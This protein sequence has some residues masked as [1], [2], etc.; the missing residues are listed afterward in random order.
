[1]ESRFLKC[2]N[3]KVNMFCTLAVYAGKN[4][5]DTDFNSSFSVD[6]LFTLVKT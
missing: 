4:P 3:K 5:D 1:M 6:R 2:K